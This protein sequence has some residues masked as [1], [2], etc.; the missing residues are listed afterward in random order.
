MIEEFPPEVVAQ[1]ARHMNDDHADDNVLIVRGLG[2]AHA[3]TAA[4]MAGMDPDGIDFAAAVNGVEVPI[5]IPFRERITERH[6]RP[7]PT[8]DLWSDGPA[9]RCGL[10][11]RSPAHRR[12]GCCGVSERSSTRFAL[13]TY[14]NQSRGVSE[15]GP[16]CLLIASSAR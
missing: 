6:H 2:G 3:A 13:S 9:A 11:I 4:R 14:W 15:P 5:R 1:I 8:P 10:R 12:A 7:G 16:S